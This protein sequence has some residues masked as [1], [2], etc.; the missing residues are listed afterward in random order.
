MKEAG[1]GQVYIF[2]LSGRIVRSVFDGHLP[3]GK[4]SLTWNGGNASGDRVAGVY[5]CRFVTPG[6]VF[7]DKVQIQ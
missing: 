7:T 2:D 1:E 6:K 4:S 3:K 5:L